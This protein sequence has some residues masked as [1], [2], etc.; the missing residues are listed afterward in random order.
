MVRCAWYNIW[1]QPFQVCQVYSCKWWGLLDTTLY[2]KIVWLENKFVRHFRQMYSW[3][4][5]QIFNNNYRLQARSYFTPKLM[6]F[7]LIFKEHMVTFFKWPHFNTFY[8]ELK[9]MVLTLTCI[10]FI[11]QCILSLPL[12]WANTYSEW[13][14]LHNFTIFKFDLFQQALV[15]IQIS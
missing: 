13:I 2:D 14:G 15:W 7:N 5:K 8:F 10:Y 11:Y 4:Q 6:H 1:N 3:M 12:F 9:Y